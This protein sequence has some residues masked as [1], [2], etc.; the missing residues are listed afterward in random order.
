VGTA[1]AG[2]FTVLSV[3]SADLLYA[4]VP[5]GSWS[6]VANGHRLPAGSVG[7]VASAWTLPTGREAVVLARA[8]SGGQH[9]ADLVMILL[10][11]VALGVARRALR[12]RPGLPFT[13]VN[14]EL[15]SPGAEVLEIDWSSVLDGQSVG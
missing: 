9:L 12:R 15:G 11:L 1:G 2:T 5:P 6:L 3:A 10:W 13:M 7:S 14:L 4:S 8:G